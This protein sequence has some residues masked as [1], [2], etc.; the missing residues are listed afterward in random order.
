MGQV[1]LRLISLIILTIAIN[2]I[3]NSKDIVNKFFNNSNINSNIKTVKI[4]GLIFS[5]LGIYMFYMTVI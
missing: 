1:F 5:W 2:F 4:I 3:F